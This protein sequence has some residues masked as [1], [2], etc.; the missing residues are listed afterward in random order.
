RA[1][2]NG[3]SKHCPK[4]AKCRCRFRRLSGHPASGCVLISL[5]FRGWSILSK[6]FPEYIT[7]ETQSH[8][9]LAKEFDAQ[10]SPCLC[11]SVAGLNSHERKQTTNTQQRQNLLPGNS[12]R[13]YSDIVEV[14]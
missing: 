10:N 14:L 3:F 2:P 12:G 4:T 7:T 11:A 9:E 13:G 6:K 1:T 5:G 8:R